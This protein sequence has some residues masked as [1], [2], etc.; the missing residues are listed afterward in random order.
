MEK[1]L[2]Q[3]VHHHD[4]LRMVLHHSDGKWQQENKATEHK[5]FQFDW[6]DLSQREDWKTEMA[7]YADAI[8]ASF[9]L[10]TGPLFKVCLFKL[11]N[12]DCILLVIHHLVVDGVSWRILLEDLESLYKGLNEGKQVELPQ[13]TDSYQRWAK[14]L[15]KYAESVQLAEE[16]PYWESV[17]AHE[18]VPIYNTKA[19][20]DLKKGSLQKVSF[21]LDRNHVELL[22]TKTHRVYN[23]EINDILLSALGIG[24]G[25]VFRTQHVLLDLE[26]HGREG[27][28]ET[29]DITR[30]V[31]WF[32]SVFPFV[33]DT[34]LSN[35]NLRDALIQTKESLRKLPHKG[36]GYGIMHQLGAGFEPSL[37]SSIVFNYLGDFGAANDQGHLFSHSEEYQGTSIALENLMSDPR[38]Q[39]NA[40]LSAGVLHVDIEYNDRAFENAQVQALA[41]AYHQALSTL[42]E[43]LSQ[44]KGTYLTPSDLTYPHL[45]SHELAALNVDGQVEDAYRLSPLQEGILYHWLSAKGSD[46]AY[47]TQ[48]SYRLRMPKVSISNIQQSY[49][50]LID[51]HSILR[52]GFIQ[53][54]DVLLQVVKKKVANSFYVEDITNRGNNEEKALFVAAFKK[55]DIAQSFSPDQDSLIRL[56]VIQ[57]D[58]ENYEFI[59]TIHHILMDGWCNSI[60]INEFYQILMSLE[61]GRPLTLPEVTPYVT[62]INWLEKLDQSVSK[63][64]W[65][66]YLSAYDSK[67]VLPFGKTG[68]A[69]NSY[70]QAEHS[71]IIETKQYQ[72]L[73]ELAAQYSFTENTFLQTAWGYLLS[74]YN[75]TRDV[76]FGSVVSGRPEEVAHVED[77]VGL[78]INTIPVRVQYTDGMTVLELI[79]NQQTTSISSL[80]HHYLSLSEIQASSELENDLIDHIYLFQ[81][82]AINELD[83][84]FTAAEGIKESL[85]VLSIDHIEQTHYNFNI[86]VMPHGDSLEI[87]FSYNQNVYAEN[88]ILH[89]LEHLKNV[90]HQFVESPKKALSHV[91][92]LTPSDKS[93]L[94]HFN[95][96]EVSYDFDRTILS[97]FKDRVLS[98]PDRIA[99]WY[100]T[101]SL[102]YAALDAY[103]NQLAHYLQQVHGVGNGD[104]VG[105]H[106]DRSHWML[107]SI[108][109][110]LKS[111]SAYVPIDMEYPADR[112]AFIGEDSGFKVCIDQAFLNVF[113]SEQ[114]NYSA[115]P[116]EVEV[117]GS[118]PAYAIYTSGSTGRPKGVLNRHESLYNRLLWMREGLGIGESD[119]LLQKTPYTF[120][121]SVWELLMLCVSGSQLVFLPPGV[122]K[123][124]FCSTA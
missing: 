89:I 76:V 30:T 41:L 4:A 27:V 92:Y 50:T 124:P 98:A 78:F 99:V 112:I 59:W 88:S 61:A 91:N 113:Q 84:A 19:A 54:F 42:I 117:T 81:N 2:E 109:G 14:S 45:T 10:E 1:S 118:T 80:N 46:A 85:S 79:Q 68:F 16:R 31:G 34:A 90:I 56:S 121:V 114:N 70:V 115:Q 53:E 119:I 96:T 106:L 18:I 108:L 49:N 23:T 44:E 64:F 38:L 87:K 103:S 21:D 35:S 111:G 52:T 12:K 75:N 48:R 26:G 39:V 47:L 24:L 65:E 51:R 66:N 25:Q 37:D 55:K 43:Q 104:L 6:Y 58:K 15:Y 107:V 116:P 82:Y 83:E 100:E 62:Y 13:K 94:A 72:H 122:T 67:A 93:Q 5:S 97:E 9:H 60:L 77:I 20:S 33:L 73:R 120:D 86:L 95:A 36:I 110:V 28:L 102:S 32:T 57:L 71:I 101:E 3:L 63:S 29:L 17:L 11:K 123:T 40:L 22:Q 74:K 69:T 8:Q 105:L 7:K